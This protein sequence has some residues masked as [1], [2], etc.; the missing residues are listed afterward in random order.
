[1]PGGRAETGHT[2]LGTRVYTRSGEGQLLRVVPFGTC[3]RC[4]DVEGRLDPEQDTVV[5]GNEGCTQALSY[6]LDRAIVGMEEREVYVD[7]AELRPVD[8]AP[9]D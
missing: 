8:P 4:G 1:V 5:C 7:P 6:V 2:E 3:R 9:Y